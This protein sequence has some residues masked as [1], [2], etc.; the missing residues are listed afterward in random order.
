MGANINWFTSRKI[1]R[2]C[3]N[4]SDECIN[5]VKSFEGFSST[6]YK[7]CV[8]VST[9]GYGMTGKE[10]NGIT[11]ISEPQAS[12]M[13]KEL[14]NKSYGSVINNDL[15]SRRVVLNQ[16]QFDAIVSMAYNVGT[17][18]LLSSTLYRNIIAGIRDRPTITTD[19]QMW[20]KAGGNTV[21]G[22]LRRRTAEAEMFLAG[23]NII[24]T[25]N[26]V[27]SVNEMPIKLGENS[28]R[29]RLLQAILNVIFGGIS[30]DG[31]FGSRTLIAVER[32]QKA[33]G[34]TVD[35]IVGS[36]TITMLIADIKNNYFKL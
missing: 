1:R 23:N 10:I 24:T 14:I 28:K 29:V 22:L 31:D 19:F 20:D 17:A 2:D 21:Q 5:F 9:L 4:V 16:N 15:V 6:I 7:D 11:S 18:G 3:M 32:Y 12:S 27:R 8:G 30:V 25:A 33:M 36:K 35:G 26:I 34:L 13:L